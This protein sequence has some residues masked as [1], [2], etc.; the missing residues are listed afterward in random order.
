M[1]EIF[2][3]VIK[4]RPEVRL[5]AQTKRSNK[6]KMTIGWR[7][8]WNGWIALRNELNLPTA[9]RPAGIARVN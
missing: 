9:K 2:K 7:S 8:T 1:D 6:L 5:S 3:K 4:E